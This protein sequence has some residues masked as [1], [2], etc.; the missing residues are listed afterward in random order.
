MTDIDLQK[1]LIDL[2]KPEKV[3]KWISFPG[4]NLNIEADV[5]SVLSQIPSKIQFLY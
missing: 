2:Q 5:T 3:A 1:L 4:A